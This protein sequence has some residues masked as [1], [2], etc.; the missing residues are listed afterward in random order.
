M[1]THLQT[2][3]DNLI[4]QTEESAEELTDQIEELARFGLITDEQ[5]TELTT[6]IGDVLDQ[7]EHDLGE[8]VNNPNKL[9]YYEVTLTAEYV[10]MSGVEA[11][12]KRDAVSQAKSQLNRD[13]AEGK[14]RLE[15]FEITAQVTND[16][17]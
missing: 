15:D 12:L 9:K 5:A 11:K 3:T 8:K 10:G 6:T 1:C 4:P 14:L 2:M 17:S 13:I 16:T 7:L